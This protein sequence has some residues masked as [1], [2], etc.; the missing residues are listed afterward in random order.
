MNNGAENELF[1]KLWWLTTIVL[2]LNQCHRNFSPW[3][4]VKVFDAFEPNS[5][6]LLSFMMSRN[7]TGELR[8]NTFFLHQ[9]WI[10]TCVCIISAHGVGSE[11][12][13][14]SPDVGQSECSQLQTSWGIRLPWKRIKVFPPSSVFKAVWTCPSL[15]HTQVAPLSISLSDLRQ[16]SQPTH[17]G[18]V[19]GLPVCLW[20]FFPS[21]LFN[22]SPA[23]WTA[24]N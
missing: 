20:T 11:V 12:C 17:G 21:V 1:C 14:L 8:V 19:G 18:H 10:L 15:S 7:H 5:S 6:I 24:G 4:L 23:A 22:S 2:S 9:S 13:S 16:T 3:K